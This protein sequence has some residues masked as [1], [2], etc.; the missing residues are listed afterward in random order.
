MPR[1]PYIF[2]D[3]PREIPRHP[4]LNEKSTHNVS[5][6]C[7]CIPANSKILSV[8]PRISGIASAVHRRIVL[9]H[10]K[11]AATKVLFNQTQRGCTE[12]PAEESV[13]FFNGIKAGRGWQ[14]MASSLPG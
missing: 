2:A 4:N 9:D 7:T 13:G 11:L 5:H 8:E 14:V 3:Q 10:V 6:R 1:D 12:M